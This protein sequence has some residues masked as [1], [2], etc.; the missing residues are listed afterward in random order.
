MRF[1]V[2]YEKQGLPDLRISGVE[3]ATFEGGEIQ[4]L[5]DELDPDDLQTYS[6]WRSTVRADR[7]GIV[8][9]RVGA[10]RSPS[11]CAT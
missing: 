3:Q 7:D 11:A 1:V 9:S 8:A 10:T 5:E 2:L 4:H 6:G